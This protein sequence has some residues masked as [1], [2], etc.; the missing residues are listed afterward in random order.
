MCIRDSNITR[1]EWIAAMQHKE[2]YSIYRVYFIRGGVVMYII[3]N[4]YQKK[5]DNI[6]AVS[7]THLL[8]CNY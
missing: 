5:M 8:Y 4:P 3:K 1:N 6:I 7:Y 2:F